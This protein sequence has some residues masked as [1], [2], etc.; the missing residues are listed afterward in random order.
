MEQWF[1][2]LR[3]NIGELDNEIQ[4]K[5]Y[6]SFYKFVYKD[7]FFI[8]REHQLTEDII[9]E[10]FVKALTQG[11]KIP[12]MNNLPAWIRKVARNAT[13]DWL[14][15]NKKKQQEIDW[16]SVIINEQQVIASNEI[17]SEEVENKLRS[18]M[19]H[20]AIQE[21]KPEHRILIIM[22]YLEEKSYKEICKELHLSEQ[23]VTQRLARARKKLL[24]YYLRKWND[25]YE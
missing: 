20:Q 5:I 22:F 9:H 8:I 17:I 16:D 25:S 7:I 12:H 3:A 21:L 24:K 15:K 1:F 18:E 11:P 4:E 10:A 6:Q 23:V 2:F 13:I 14:R 19:L